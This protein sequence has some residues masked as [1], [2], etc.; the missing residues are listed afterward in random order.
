MGMGSSGKGG[1][2][3]QPSYQPQSAFGGKGGGMRNIVNQLSQT[4]AGQQAG[5]GGKGKGGAQAGTQ[6]TQNP[7]VPPTQPQVQQ[8]APQQYYQPQYQPDTFQNP[9]AQGGFGQQM[10]GM[11]GKGGQMGQYQQIP[12]WLQQGGMGGKGG[13]MKQPQMGGFRHRGWEGRHQQPQGLAGLQQPT[14]TTEALTPTPASDQP[15][16]GNYLQ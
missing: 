6:P 9:Y 5:M 4:P 11:G 7:Y 8:P 3:A 10:G 14:A 12:T 13:Q 15:Y 16:M 1:G 2:S